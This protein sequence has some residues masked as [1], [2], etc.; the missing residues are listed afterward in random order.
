MRGVL[1]LL[2]VVVAHGFP[3]FAETFSV[4]F[5]SSSATTLSEIRPNNNFGK[6]IHFAAGT[7]QNPLGTEP[8]LYPRNRG[9]IQ[10]DIAS[11]IPAGATILSAQLVLWVI[12]QPPADEGQPN[13]TF[14]IH[15][16]LS[17]WV[18]GEGV[19]GGGPPIGSPALEGETTWNSRQHGLLA[20]GAPGGDAGVD[21]FATPSTSIFVGSPDVGQTDCNPCGSAISLMLAADV[22]YWLDNPTQNHGLLIKAQDEIAAWSTKQFMVPESQIDDF[23]RLTVT[24]TVEAVPEPSTLAFVGVGTLALLPLLRR[25]RRA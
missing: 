23:P 10:F 17:S 18:E 5:G 22:Q 16:M 25:A 2:L 14:D 19:A 3:L 6:E 8:F 12:L 9:L 4:E 13:M 15:R 1:L 11:N 21:Y 7:L 20:W 24:Y